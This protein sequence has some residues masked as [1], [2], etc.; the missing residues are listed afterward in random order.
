M[1][2]K[3]P[4]T[5]AQLKQSCESYLEILYRQGK[6]IWF[7]LNAGGI[8]T[9][10]KG[11]K[12]YMIRLCPPGTSDSVVI[13]PNPTRVIFVEWK[14]PGKKQTEQQVR[15]DKVVSEQGHNYWLVSDAEAFFDAIKE[16]LG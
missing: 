12:K 3:M 13:L 10:G 1:S 7:R 5:E 16:L 6:L 9:E 14:A 2:N 11:G 8:L 15:F 4:L